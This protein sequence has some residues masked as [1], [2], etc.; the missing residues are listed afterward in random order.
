MFLSVELS[1][2]RPVYPKVHPLGKLFQ[3]IKSKTSALFHKIPEP[4]DRHDTTFVC[5]SVFRR[6]DLANNGAWFVRAATCTHSQWSH[7]PTQPQQWRLPQRS[8]PGRYREPHAKDIFPT[9]NWREDKTHTRRFTLMR[10]VDYVWQPQPRL[11]Q[12]QVASNETN[13][14]SI[15]ETCL[16]HVARGRCEH[17]VCAVSQKH[18]PAAMCHTSVFRSEDCHQSHVCVVV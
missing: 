14:I 18:L 9:G 11:R 15:R 2:R 17:V 12:A 4:Q 10:H 6:A 13:C 5:K 1:F 8:L 3:S 16:R 7:R